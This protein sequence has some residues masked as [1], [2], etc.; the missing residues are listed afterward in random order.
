M[1]HNMRKYRLMPE[2]IYSKRNHLADDGTLSKVLFYDIVQQ[3]WHPA[4]L[5]LVDA[6]NCY[7][8]IAHPMV[9]M[10]FQSFGV[11]TSAVESMLTTIQNMEFYLQTGY[12]DSNGCAG[13]VDDSSRDD[14]KTQGMCQGNGSAPAAW[15]ATSIPMIAIQR[16]KDYGAHLIA[17]IS[18][19]QGH[20]IGELFIDNN[21]TNLFH[22]EMR[23]NE[24]VFQAHSKLQDGII[25]WGKLLIATGGALTPPKCSY[26][27]ILSDGNQTEHGS[28]KTIL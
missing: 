5:A 15:T 18:S 6:D 23:R 9:S 7:D 24:N 25:S 13:G 19:Q 10:V 21:D 1:L 2:E 16:R 26:Y 20:F 11:P 27:L 14:R 3:L 22:L 12:G 4:G 8:C 28:M 17:P